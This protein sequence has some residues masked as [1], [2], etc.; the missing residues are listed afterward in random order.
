MEAY[1]RHMESI[2]KKLEDSDS[3]FYKDPGLYNF[4]L[5]KAH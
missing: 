3:Y 1:S 2:E 4:I 5:E